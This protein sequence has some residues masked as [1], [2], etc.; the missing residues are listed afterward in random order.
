MNK[1][2]MK[3]LLPSLMVCMIV[4]MVGCSVNDENVFVD[5]GNRL[6]DSDMNSGAVY[7]GEWTVNRQVV[8]TALLRVREK[9]YLEMCVRLPEHYLLGLC[10]PNGEW[11]ATAEDVKPAGVPSQITAYVQGY[12][13]QTQYMSFVSANQKNGS[14]LLFSTCSMVAFVNGSRCLVTLLSR[15]NASAI[16]QGTGLWTLAIPVDC[17]V[18]TDETTGQETMREL[19]T[20]VT[21]YYN[22]KR[23][24]Q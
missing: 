11:D 14:Q 18:V 24:M 4:M 15:E 5:L 7:D 6:D 1:K 10:S 13:E 21:L 19:P 20:T 2:V 23:R 16:L 3:K 22:A 8:D 17:I 12:S 9:G